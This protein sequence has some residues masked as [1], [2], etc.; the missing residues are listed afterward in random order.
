MGQFMVNLSHLSQP[1]SQDK[2]STLEMANCLFIL[3]SALVAVTFANRGLVRLDQAAKD[4]FV[5]RHNKHRAE[6]RAHEPNV[7]WDETLARTA[8]NYAQACHFGHDMN[9]VYGENIYA[10]WGPGYTTAA[11]EAEKAVDSWHSEIANVDGR[12]D[13]I[14]RHDKKT[15]GHYSQ[16]VW[17]KTTKIGCAIARGCAWGSNEMN[18]V[19]CEYSPRG[20]MMKSWTEANPPY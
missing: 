15:C 11:A 4:A 17:A 7:S 19:F 1:T 18:F 10:G 8:A 12:W 5:N 13:C 20:N 16:E 6:T 9:N 14:A 3:L 2:V